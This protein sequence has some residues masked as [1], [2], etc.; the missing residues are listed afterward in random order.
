ML[1]G[2]I[3]LQLQFTPKGG[4]ILGCSFLDA[5]FKQQL[6]QISGSLDASGSVHDVFSEKTVPQ[7]LFRPN[8]A[9]VHA[10]I[11]RFQEV[12]GKLGD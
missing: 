9:V 10:F 1:L 4:D 3:P 11:R 8:L 12:L 6:F 7:S 5:H 2:S